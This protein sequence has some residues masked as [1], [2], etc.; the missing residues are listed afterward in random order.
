VPNIRKKPVLHLSKYGM[1]TKS[2]TLAHASN[3]VYH[4]NTCNTHCDK[5]CWYLKINFI[6]ETMQHAQCTVTKKILNSSSFCTVT[7][8][9]HHAKLTASWKMTMMTG[10]QMNNEMK[11]AK[12]TTTI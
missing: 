6:P 10:M 12:A 9:Q 8:A 1:L 2:T 3:N 7:P 11:F 5:G 4:N